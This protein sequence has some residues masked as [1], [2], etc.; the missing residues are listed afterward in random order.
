MILLGP[1]IGTIM[2]ITYQAAQET[3]IN[4]LK[5]E[6]SS[7]AKKEAL[8]S[9]LPAFK[10]LIAEQIANA[11]TEQIKLRA[12][13][14]VQ[15]V[16]NLELEVGFEKSEGKDFVSIAEKSLKRLGIFIEEN[17]TQESPVISYLKKRYDEEGIRQFTGR[18]YAG[19]FIKREGE[20]VYNVYNKMAYAPLVDKNKPWLSSETTA[21]GIGDIIAQRASEIFEEEFNLS[22]GTD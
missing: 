2:S 14:Y 3:I 13:G 20:G 15:A 6:V 11:Y 4:G 1:F 17:N 7:A 12:E 18:L 21:E 16:A 10:A 5:K 19:H 9:Q 22:L 8:R